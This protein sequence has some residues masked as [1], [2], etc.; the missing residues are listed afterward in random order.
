MTRYRS[1]LSITSVLSPLPPPQYWHCTGR[2]WSPCLWKARR[3][4]GTNVR[5]QTQDFKLP[6]ESFFCCCTES[7]FATGSAC[8]PAQGAW[9]SLLIPLVNSAL[10]RQCASQLYSYVLG[11]HH[12]CN[13]TFHECQQRTE[14][15][16]LECCRLRQ[17]PGKKRHEDISVQS[18]MNLTWHNCKASLDLFVCDFMS[19]YVIDALFLF[20]LQCHFNRCFGNLAH[21]FSPN[22]F[23][24][25]Q[26]GG[27][28]KEKNTECVI[29][30]PWR[31]I[32]YWR[33][34]LT[35]FMAVSQCASHQRK[36]RLTVEFA[37]L[38]Q[39]AEQIEPYS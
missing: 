11:K 9:Y 25:L 20:T 13:A 1:A 24:A 18:F 38:K 14:N 2:I 29:W 3:L 39:V 16:N 22:V 5:T 37:E 26:D 31:L 28:K 15:M 12:Y 27:L 8:S 10:Q 30:R 17:R 35:S 6:Q 36:Y 7:T 4:H 19:K 33:S 32:T 21:L 23:Q 34:V